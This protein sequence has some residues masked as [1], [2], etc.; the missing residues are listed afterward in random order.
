MKK[1][2]PLLIIVLLHLPAHA[3]QDL[4]Y[5]KFKPSEVLPKQEVIVTTWNSKTGLDRLSSAQ[6]KTDFYQLAHHYQPQ[7]NPLYCGIASSVILLNAFNQGSSVVPSQKAL[8]V[9]KPKVWG[10]GSVPFHAYSQISLLNDKTEMVKSREVIRL[11]NINAENE[12][13]AKAFDPGLSLQQLS[14]VLK[15]YGLKTNAVHADKDLEAGTKMFRDKIKAVLKN[16]TEFA[17]VNFK[18]KKMGLPTGGH[19]SPLAAYDDKSDSVLILDVA[20][21]KNPWY[22]VPVQHLYGAMHTKD[23]DNYRGYV[24]VSK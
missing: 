1:L 13:N 5:G 18:G 11:Q 10:G 12:N 9:K 17:L 19:I 4:T 3:K 20:G 24:I 16:S 8:E 21:H 2:I 22:W 14:G 7:I 6:Y 23:G 15:A